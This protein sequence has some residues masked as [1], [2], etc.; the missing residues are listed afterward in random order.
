MPKNRNG[1]RNNTSYDAL[2]LANR[3]NNDESHTESAVVAPRGILPRRSAAPCSRK[4]QRRG[5]RGTD[6]GG[7]KRGTL[8]GGGGGG[9]KDVRTRIA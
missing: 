4:G 5:G 6:G 2:V 7:R 3:R 1:R 8:D 9:A